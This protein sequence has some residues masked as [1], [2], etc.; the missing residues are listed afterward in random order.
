[1][2]SGVRKSRTVPPTKDSSN[3][4]Q[5]ST[6]RGTV[7]YPDKSPAIGLSVVAFD[8]DAASEDRLGD[9]ITDEKGGYRIAY[10]DAVFRRPPNGSRGADV[11]VRVHGANGDLPFQSRTRRNAPA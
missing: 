9:A 8:R 7:C 3:P 5:R 10:G 1:T 6:V 11:F 4:V 2:K